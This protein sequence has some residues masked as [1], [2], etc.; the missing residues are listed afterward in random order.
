MGMGI[1]GPL[2]KTIVFWRAEQHSTPQKLPALRVIFPMKPSGYCSFTVVH[3]QPAV[4]G[5][6]IPA[7]GLTVFFV[8]RRITGTHRFSIR[9]V[10]ASEDAA[11]WL[12]SGRVSR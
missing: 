8:S 7:A 2:T 10:L 12:R 5:E 11:V 6:W 3:A 4:P 1:D 9:T